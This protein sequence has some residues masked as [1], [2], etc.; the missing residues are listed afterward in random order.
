MSVAQ[1]H[2]TLSSHESAAT[3]VRHRC[4]HRR[5]AAC[6]QERV[7]RT[8]ID[9]AGD[10]AAEETL[11]EDDCAAGCDSP[12]RQLHGEGENRNRY[13]VV[14]YT[15]YASEMPIAVYR[16]ESLEDAHGFVVEFEKRDLPLATEIVLDRTGASDGDH[17]SAA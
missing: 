16:A 14:T 15:R 5:C 7:C 4:L 6:A 9:A 13:L 2:P 1:S 10:D 3:L 11:D 17:H 12:L 8:Q